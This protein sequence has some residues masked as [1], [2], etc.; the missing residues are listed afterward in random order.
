LDK[1]VQVTLWHPINAPVERV[2]DWR[3]YLMD[4]GIRQPFK[5][6]F[7]EVYL[8][9]DAE[10]RTETYSNRFAAHLLR[11]DRF[12][13]LCKARGWTPSALRRAQPPAP[14]RTWA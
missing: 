7:R 14:Y 8:L 13:A 9:T 12:A 10:L 4:R 11:K 5:Q 2:A 3:Q 1:T 6:S